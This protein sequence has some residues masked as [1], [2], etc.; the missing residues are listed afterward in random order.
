MSGDIVPVNLT[1]ERIVT[2][3][4]N[5]PADL[6]RQLE[7]SHPKREDVCF[8]STSE[9]FPIVI[10]P[11]CVLQI[12]TRRF[13]DERQLFLAILEVLMETFDYSG[14]FYVYIVVPAEDF[15]TWRSEGAPYR[16][17]DLKNVQVRQRVMSL[18]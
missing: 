4:G 10:T 6:K 3:E 16:V 15:D 12:T 5:E 2:F 17:D 11:N 13:R 14:P 9:T 8:M 18:Y 1:I 7:K